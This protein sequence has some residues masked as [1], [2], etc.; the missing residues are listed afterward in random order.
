[1]KTCN[2]RVMCLVKPRCMNLMGLS[3]TAGSVV[4]SNDISVKFW[5]FCWTFQRRWQW[6]ACC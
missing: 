2:E 6:R 1:M 4:Y 3:V 5:K